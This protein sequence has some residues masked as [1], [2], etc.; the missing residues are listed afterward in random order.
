MK[1]VCAKVVVCNLYMGWGGNVLIVKIM[2]CVVCVIM[3]INII[4]GISFIGFVDLIRRGT[5]LCCFVLF[6]DLC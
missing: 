5:M 3:E 1:V 6:L 4:C 2:I